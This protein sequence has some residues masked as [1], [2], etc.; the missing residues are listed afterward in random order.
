MISG[1]E[2]QREGGPIQAKETEETDTGG[3][4]IALYVGTGGSY[5]R[6]G[7]F[8]LIMLWIMFIILF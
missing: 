7:W 6:L 8:V 5:S 4:L 3:T 2:T 1:E